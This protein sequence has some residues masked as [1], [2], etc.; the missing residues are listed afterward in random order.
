MRECSNCER[1]KQRIAELKSELLVLKI[2]AFESKMT[3][4]FNSHSAPAGMRN[5]KS[6]RARIGPDQG[7]GLRPAST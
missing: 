4:A 6:A 1:L 3:A 2:A 5:K 7:R